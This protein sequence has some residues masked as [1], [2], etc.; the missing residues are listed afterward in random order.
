M[1]YYYGRKKRFIDAYPAAEYGTVIE[2]FAG[3][4]SYSCRPDNRGR[5]IML[6][7]RDEQVA[8]LWH[9]LQRMTV[10]ELDAM[11]DLQVGEMTDDLFHLLHM[12]SKRWYTYRKATVT[13]IMAHNWMV[14]RPYY[15]EMLPFIREWTVTQGDYR[16][17]PDIEATWFIDPPY[18]GA[19]GD[20][21]RHGSAGFDYTELAEWCRSRQG[22][23]IVCSG[24]DDKW[25]PFTPFVV[26]KGVGGKQFAEGIWSNRP[27]PEHDLQLGLF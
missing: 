3:A 25:L 24:A 9:R 8:A 12:V 27:L 5:T 16:D 18:P 14:A 2:P 6:I 21:Y 26:G 20:G 1:F 17:A 15:R 19:P 22:Q 7:E 4:A 13:P 10:D 23:V 11:P